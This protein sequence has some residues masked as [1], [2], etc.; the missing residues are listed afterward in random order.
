MA[1]MRSLNTWA[2]ILLASSEFFIGTFARECIFNSPSNIG[3]RSEDDL[4]SDFAGCTTIVADNI[5]IGNLRGSL[6]VRD[7]VNITG[8]LIIPNNDDE[9]GLPVLESVEFPDLEY[10]G[11]LDIYEVNDLQSFTF[12]NLKRVSGKI[13]ITAIEKDAY[14]DFGKLEHAGALRLDG[15]FKEIDLYELQTVDN[16]LII[17]SCEGCSAKDSSGRSHVPDNVP[18][19]NLANLRS[20]GYIKIAGVVHFGWMSELTTIGPPADPGNSELSTDSGARLYFNETTDAVGLNLTRL[21]SVD[22]QLFINGYIKSLQMDALRTTNASIYI[23]AAKALNIDLPLESA[24]SIDLEGRITSVHLPNLTPN[25]PLTLNSDYACKGHTSLTDVTCPA[26]PKF[27][28]A[29]K[30]G[31]AVGIVV[32]LALGILAVL[33]CCRRSRKRE[34][35]RL[36]TLRTRDEL[37]DLPAYAPGAVGAT[38]GESSTALRPDT[39]PPPYEA[40]RET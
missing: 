32:A 33:L 15:R 26:P 31:L 22:K 17:R 2:W 3:Y 7:V 12:S 16:D 1:V 8:T 25:T 23:D 36:R 4:Q 35:E 14:V 19:I 18:F 5:T 39:P 24:G 13:D 9:W 27:T 28:T 10:L 11:G 29:A 30:V 37:A 34:A 40:R 21:E 38:G 20:V 6:I